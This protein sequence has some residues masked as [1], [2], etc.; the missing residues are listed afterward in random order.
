MSYQRAK[1]YAALGRGLKKYAAQTAM[2]YGVPTALS[3]G[4][5]RAYKSYNAPYG[6]PMHTGLSGQGF[7]GGASPIK[8]GSYKRS[9]KRRKQKAKQFKK[10]TNNKIKKEI[11]SLKNKV[12]DLE[13][14][15]NASL[16][17]YTRRDL[18]PHQIVAGNNV[19][20]TITFPIN[21][22]D[23]YARVLSGLKYYNPSNPS[24]LIT[25][26]ASTGSYSKDF[27]V[28][29]LYSKLTVRNNFQTDCTATVYLCVVKTDTSQTPLGSWNDGIDTDAGSVT[30]TTELAQYP[31]DFDVFNSTWRIE[32][33]VRKDLSPGQSFECSHSLKDL[34]YDPALINEEDAV[35]KKND[36]SSAW[37]VVVHGT[38]SHDTA[39]NNKVGYAPSGIDMVQ[40]STWK[41]EYNAGVNLS[42]VD[43]VND[44]SI[45]TNT[46][47]QSHQPKPDNIGYSVA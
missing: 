16:G 42:Y 31:S 35:Y 11:V 8:S 37:L 33:S 41:V 2:F 1:T 26:D 36:K 38:I 25:A 6:G 9:R 10:L 27:L 14:S 20:S 22:A 12:K 29:S 43:S 45:P 24:T 21:S 30:S 13:H 3:Y 46:Y 4:A 5:S 17:R 34:E 39:V 40:S 15:E 7:R 28:K 19:Q 44:L 18:V 23:T 32:K 47:V